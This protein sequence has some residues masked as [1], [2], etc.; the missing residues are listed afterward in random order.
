MQV[1][2]SRRQ[3]RKLVPGYQ[4]VREILRLSTHPLTQILSRLTAK[5]P[6]VV[7]LRRPH[8]IFLTHNLLL[9]TIKIF[10]H[11]AQGPQ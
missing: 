5:S 7:T 3:A 1:R 6:F 9:D 11:G 8:S 2:R 4:I 10:K